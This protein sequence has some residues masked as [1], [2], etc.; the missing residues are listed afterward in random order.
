MTDEKTESGLDKI[1]MHGGA[2]ANIGHPEWLDDQERA[3]WA[4][5]YGAAFERR[6]ADTMAMY[7]TANKAAIVADFA[8]LRLRQLRDGNGPVAGKEIDVA[9]CAKVYPELRLRRHGDDE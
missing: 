9:R 5:A 8:V 4:A 3:I 7:A 6:F 2:R 1:G